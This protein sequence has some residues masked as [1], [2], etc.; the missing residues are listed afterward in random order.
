M[1]SHTPTPPRQTSPTRPRRVLLIGWD[2]ADWQ[3]INPLIAQGHMPTLAR[4]I[5]QGVSGNLASMQ[6]MLSPLLWN[7][8]ATGKRPDQHGVHGFTEPDPNA[9]AVR[10][11][12]STSRN[13][14]A[15]WNIA[16]Q[17]GLRTHVVGWY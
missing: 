7:T 4:M 10:P 9:A 14:K 2:A 17:S 16:T 11:V 1:T 15:L 5:E 12:S 3:L 8:I 6:P 13:C